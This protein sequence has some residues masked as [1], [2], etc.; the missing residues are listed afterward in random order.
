MGERQENRPAPS[1][2]QQIESSYERQERMES[3]V[4][5]IEM[6]PSVTIN[7]QNEKKKMEANGPISAVA[8]RFQDPFFGFSVGL[9][10]G[11]VSQL[12]LSFFSLSLLSHFMFLFIPVCLVI[13]L[14]SPFK[15]PFHQFPY[16]LPSSPLHPVFFVRVCVF[17]FYFFGI[18]GW[19]EGEYRS[20]YSQFTM[21]SSI[22]LYKMSGWD[23]WYFAS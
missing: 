21:V 13:S 6:C 19:I 3:S 1:T 12:L 9:V 22:F 11:V 20:P 14:F 15:V 4:T 7:W 16:S 2:R 8:L 10:W 18:S 5:D 23:C 17:I